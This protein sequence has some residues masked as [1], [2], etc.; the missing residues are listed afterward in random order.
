MITRG[1]VVMAL[2]MCLLAPYLAA[3][4]VDKTPSET[5]DRKADLDT[6]VKDAQTYD[7]RLQT[8]T[9]VL[10]QL[11]PQPVMNWNGSAFV[12]LD[13]GRPEVIG[14]FWK[15]ADNPPGH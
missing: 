11:S 4:T 5:A 12:W 9:P 3:Q 1:S 14:T 2:T 10:L 7:F 13:P 6:F 15:T 8:E